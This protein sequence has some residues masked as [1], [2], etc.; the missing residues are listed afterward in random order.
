MFLVSCKV[1]AEW[2][3]TGWVQFMKSSRAFSPLGPNV[4]LPISHL[5]RVTSRWPVCC[6]ACAPDVSSI[7]SSVLSFIDVSVLMLLF[8]WDN[9]TTACI[10]DCREL[11]T[12]TRHWKQCSRYRQFHFSLPKIYGNTQN[13]FRNSHIAVKKMFFRTPNGI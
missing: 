9:I 10:S 8:L 2:N 4:W 11:W 7:S 12:E 13:D 5:V 3:A 1:V 6:G